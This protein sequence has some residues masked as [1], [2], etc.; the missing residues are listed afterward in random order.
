LE[1]DGMY[2]FARNY[3]EA[4]YDVDD[5]LRLRRIVKL[6]GLEKHDIISAFQLIKHNQLD[7]AVQSRIP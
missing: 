4:K 7:P 5:L 6:L 3:E 2:R 1:L